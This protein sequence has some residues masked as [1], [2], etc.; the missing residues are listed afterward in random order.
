MSHRFKRTLL[1]LIAGTALALS[2]TTTALAYGHEN[3]TQAVYQIEISANGNGPGAG[4]GIWL[5]I[6]LDASQPDS[7]SG[8]GDYTG[9][10]CFH[11]PHSGGGARAFPDRGE[12]SWTK[13]E[14]THTLT[15]YGVAIVSGA[16]P[17]PP[18]TVSSDYGHYVSTVLDTFHVPG[19]PG[20]VQIQ[21]AP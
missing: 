7:L 11:D 6:E 18:I 13:D 19:F 2:W 3:G 4:G 1:V 8:V 10:D 17:L 12:V 15:I 9:S 20:W 5:W 16:V 21:V 14:A